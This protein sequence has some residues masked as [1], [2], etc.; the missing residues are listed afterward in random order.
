[1]VDELHL[2]GKERMKVYIKNNRSL[3]KTYLPKKTLNPYVPHVTLE[4]GVRLKCGFV[5][6]LHN[7]H[8][9]FIKL[10]HITLFFFAHMC[11]ATLKP[12]EK[13]SF[14]PS[15][16]LNVLLFQS[17]YACSPR[18]II[19]GNDHATISMNKYWCWFVVC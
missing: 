13:S 7:S 6:M 2:I 10:L 5:H 15:P 12:L 19:L 16:C 4:I 18:C 9:F 8:D 3:S 11:C 1:M 14:I 17:K